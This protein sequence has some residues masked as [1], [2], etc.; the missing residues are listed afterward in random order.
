MIKLLY[1][2]NGFED[3][4]QWAIKFHGGR[5]F[6]ISGNNVKTQ[7]SKSTEYECDYEPIFGI[8]VFDKQ[9]VEVILD[10]IISELKSQ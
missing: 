5:K 7:E 4:V 6:T 1:D 10:G 2:A 9:S 3:D 8:D